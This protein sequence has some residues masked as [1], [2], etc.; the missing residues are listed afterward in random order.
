MNVSAWAIRQP[1]PALL[2]FVLLCA[3]GLAGFQ[4]LPVAKFPD[5]AL[6]VVNVVV[7]Q[8][9]ATPSQLETEVT[10]RVEDAVAS[11]TGIK[12]LVS[13]I[14]EGNSTTMIE[15]ELERDLDEAL[16]E[17]RDALSRVRSDLPSDIEEP[18]VAKVNFVGG[19][20]LTY[21]VVSARDAASGMD[22]EALSWFVDDEVRKA[23]FGVSGVAQ[24]SRTGGL[25]REVR[26]DVQPERLIGLG[27]T[28]AT[29]SQQLRAAQSEHPGGRATLAGTEQSVRTSGKVQR[30][31]ELADTLI[32]TPDGRRVRLGDIATIHDSHAEP[33]AVALLDGVPVVS[34]AVTRTRG[35]SEVDVAAAVR[36]RVDQLQR[37]FPQVR[38]EEVT[39][40]VEEAEQSY[41]SSMDMLWE[42]ALLAVLVVFLFLRDWRATWISA[43]AL[44]LSIIPT[45]FVMHL[46]GFSLNIVTLLALAVVVGIL[47]DDAIVE[48][49]NIV[50]HLR[51]GKSP[52]QAALEAA[53]EIGLA[54]IATTFTLAAVFIPVAFMP[55]IPG[56]FFR[57]FGWTAATAVL[58]S[59]VVARL[60]TPM[61]SAYQ[62]K[63]VNRPAT[64]RDGPNLNHASSAD[65]HTLRWM[66]GYL[67]L[68][69]W[70]VD[71]RRTTLLLALGFFMGSLAIVPLIPA[72]FIPPA[73]LGQSFLNIELAP[74][75]RLQD[76]QRVA[77]AARQRLADIPELQRVYSAIGGV[78]DLGDP[79]QM[80]IAEVRKAT[81]TLRWGP[82]DQRR[83]TQK[84]LEREVRSR[85]ADLPGA[86]MSFISSE[87][88]DN[89]LLVLS[90][91]DPRLL[92]GASQAVER[93]L[94]A[95]P[96]LGSVSSSAALL[97]PEIVITPDS[98]RAAE[99]GVTTAAIAEAA[100]VATQGDLRQRLPKL[101]L[102]ERQIPIRVMVA[103]A[104]LTD[105]YLLG[106]LM[107]PGRHGPVPL[108]AVADIRLDSG[109]AKITR[110]QRARNVTLTAELNGLPLGA[111]MQQVQQLPSVQQLPP[112]VRLL[113][114][115]DTEIF[116]ELFTGFLIAMVTGIA[117]VYAVLLLLFNSAL[118][119]ITILLAIPLSAGGA[120]GL[121]LL[122]QHYLS[123][124]A[125]IGLLMLIGIAT[126]NSILLVDYALI[127]ERAGLDRRSAVLDACS[128]RA[129]PVLMTTLAMGAGMLP[130]ALGLGGDATFRAPMAIAVIGGL[131]TSTL[132]SLVVI[133]AAYL[134]VARFGTWRPWRRRTV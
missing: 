118:Q 10:R 74:G 120:F 105:P 73:D 9:G 32:S 54:V 68:A 63:A 110:F 26:I 36:A 40:T 24:V 97:R 75:A 49:E 20:M 128:K 5:V 101:D 122:T 124:P 7:A 51:M 18:V 43:V 89:L 56:K 62:L 2:L 127:A 90:G 30:A 55:G 1:L 69:S 42:G 113:N 39:S 27:L 19:T 104:A 112:G 109:P 41:A 8:P 35:S 28:A 133:P 16:D 76:T 61:M 106:R 83:R 100:R 99:L 33:R 23:L 66:P 123:L 116:V 115:G 46:L 48:V 71:H 134:I 37:E 121:L 96:G 86:R 70:A 94:R 53:D 72:T 95:L 132:L 93:D 114:T 22:M 130:V 98:A 87:P 38:F 125:L 59:L 108:A 85:L 111:V 58:F 47:V 11:I 64:D 67:R 57:E 82:A 13:N 117:C 21:T 129:Q 60:L 31:A 119:P 29:V 102:P 91:D 6:P 50:R 3:A 92:V 12:N 103:D 44:P 77:E 131:I 15:F 52:R 45:F 80:Q 81:L 79:G 78:H 34:F 65:P 126:K 88:G 84:A 107:L 25:D 4:Q 14:T 17:V